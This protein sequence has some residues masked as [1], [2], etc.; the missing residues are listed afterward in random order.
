[1][2]DD[3]GDAEIEELKAENDELRELLGN[4][5]ETSRVAVGAVDTECISSGRR[6]RLIGAI[7]DVMEFAKE[8]D[9]DW[10]IEV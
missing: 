6:D 9:E 2:A 1:M 7:E 4:L 5:L 10:G 8:D 3:H